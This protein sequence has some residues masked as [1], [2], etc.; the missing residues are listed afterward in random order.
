MFKNFFVID[1]NVKMWTEIIDLVILG[2]N[3]L[4]FLQGEH[5]YIRK[6]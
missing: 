1:T 4:K 6:V 2:R 3:I 5:V